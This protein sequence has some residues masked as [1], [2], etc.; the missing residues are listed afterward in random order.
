MATVFVSGPLPGDAVERLRR[1][2]DVDG[3]RRR[4]T[5]C[6]ATAFAQ[7]AASFEAIVALLTDRDRRRRS[8]M[9][10]PRVRARRERRRRRRQ[11]RPR[12]CRARGV[13]VTNTPDVLT[14]ATADLAFG[15]LLAAARRVAEGDRLVR[16]GEFPGWTPTTLLGARVHGDDARAS[17]GLG[18][19]GQAV[20]RR[21]RGFGM[22]VSYTQ[23]TRLDEK[24][25][26][27]LG[28]TFVV[29]RRALRVVRL[30]VASTARSR[31]RRATWSSRERL[32]SMKPGS[33]LVNTSRGPCVDE[34]ALA[35][36]LE[37][38][39]LAAA[40]LDVFE[41]EPRVAP[42][43]A[44]PHE[45]RAHAAHRRAPTAARAKRWPRI[46]A[47]NVIAFARGE[48]LLTRVDQPPK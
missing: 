8:S 48:P 34:A 38:G 5:A 36:A 10:A 46:A 23:R 22:H 28:A 30:R 4:A 33:V 40:G 17:S 19:I 11:R 6:A 31:R 14:E 25:E 2:A 43:P 32:A 24:L 20:A 27:A 39:P 3:R 15:L 18:R 41:D 44:R 29:G 21:A 12:A 1:V 16:R 7:G 13:V 9:R 47:D 45:R 37:N 35:D 42:A 26:R